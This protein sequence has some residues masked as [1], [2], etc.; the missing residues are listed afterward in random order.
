M[1][2]LILVKDNEFISEMIFISFRLI[3]QFGQINVNVAVRWIFNKVV[4]INHA[5]EFFSKGA[6]FFIEIIVCC[7]LWM[8]Y[9][10]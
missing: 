1:H 3:N 5:I 9:V 4:S 7:F 6:F 2:Y 8:T 10:Y